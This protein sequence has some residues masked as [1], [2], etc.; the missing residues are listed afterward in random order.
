MKSLRIRMALVIQVGVTVW[1][2]LILKSCAESGSHPIGATAEFVSDAPVGMLFVFAWL[3]W[4]LNSPTVTEVKR[5]GILFVSLLMVGI[6][7]IIGLMLLV[8]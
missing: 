7:Y 6:V 4:E 1:C 2:A 8:G 5:F 3:L